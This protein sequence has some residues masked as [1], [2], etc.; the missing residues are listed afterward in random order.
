MIEE[1][2]KY[3]RI[4]KMDSLGCSSIDSFINDA[5]IKKSIIEKNLTSPCGLGVIKVHSFF[6]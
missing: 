5:Q 1:T 4:G 3:P 2:S 6:Y